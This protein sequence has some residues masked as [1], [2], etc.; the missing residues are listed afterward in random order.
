MWLNIVKLDNNKNNIKIKNKNNKLVKFTDFPLQCFPNFQMS[1]FD[2]SWILKKNI[3][4]KSEHSRKKKWRPIQIQ[5]MVHHT[6][7]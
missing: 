5:I 3:F 4:L 7:L 1:K 2:Y 6:L